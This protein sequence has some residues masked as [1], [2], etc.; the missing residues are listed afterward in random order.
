MQ[1]FNGF[2]VQVSVEMPVFVDAVKMWAGS[3]YIKLQSYSETEIVFAFMLIMMKVDQSMG[4]ITVQTLNSENNAA[5]LHAKCAIHAILQH[6][7]G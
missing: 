2:G 1:I 3:G 6:N 4:R 7:M 5:C